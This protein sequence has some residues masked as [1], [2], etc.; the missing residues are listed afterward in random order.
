MS[1]PASSKTIL[2][3]VEQLAQ[4][5]SASEK[6]VRR[7]ISAGVLP[8]VRIGR[9]VRVAEVDLVAFVERYRDV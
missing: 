2:Y 9:L 1:A 7:L 4:R 5:L 6:T 8:T 3:D